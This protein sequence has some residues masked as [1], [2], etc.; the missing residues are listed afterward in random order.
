MSKARVAVIG[1][2]WWASDTHLPALLA[3]PHAEVVALC[4]AD[5][6]RLT[7]VAHRF[8]IEQT[9]TELDALLAAEVLDG[10]VIV[11]SNASH[12]AVAKACLEA[13]VHVMLEKPMTLFAPEAQA[14]VELSRRVNKELIIGYPYNFAPYAT[15]ARAVIAAGE[16]GAV[17]Y[18]NLVF[19]SNMTPLFSGQGI[20]T[21][22]VHGPQQYTDPAQIGGG[23]GHVQ[24]THGAGLL[25]FVTGLRPARVS[26]LMRNHGLQV[27][28]VDVMNVAFE[29]DAVGTVSGTGNQ[30]GSVFR[31]L[32]GCE[33]G[34]VDI[35]AQHHTAAIHRN[36]EAVE[37]I[38]FDAAQAEK[39]LSHYTA[40][41]L[42]DVALGQAPNGSPPE[43]GW[44]TVELLDAAYRSASQDGQYIT[45]QA[46][47]S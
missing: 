32:V 11:S 41:N 36:G 23:H 10:V 17:Q 44:Y 38:A 7:A 34:W 20:R 15:R 6:T 40:T 37:E 1:T 42:V 5:P 46:L 31:L 26:A 2:G 16:L 14:L 25:F 12:Y 28:L 9:Y 30:Q 22:N 35:D 39:P 13:G 27:D 45:R 18:A 4:D 43:E 33:R 3:H 21:Y 8:E 29:G 19:S 47:Y 24:V